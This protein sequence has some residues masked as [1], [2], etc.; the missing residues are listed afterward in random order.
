MVDKQV[1]ELLKKGDTEILK[2]IYLSYKEDFILFAKKHSITNDTVLDIYQDVIIALMENIALGK[3]TTLKSSLKTYIFSIGKY[4]IYEYQRKNK[5]VHLTMTI[6]STESY[7]FLFQQ[8]LTSNQK[9]LYYSF[10]LLGEKCKEILT[11]FYYRGF[12][13]D[14]ISEHLNYNNKDVVKSQKS[15][16]LKNLKDKI[17]ANE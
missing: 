6:E 5:T 10:K 9:K 14:E 13:I 3:L 11:L 17:A 2:E 7:D 4:M 15:R 16:C 1:L 8:E 12:T